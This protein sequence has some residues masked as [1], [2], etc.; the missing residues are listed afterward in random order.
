MK[1]K[2]LGCVLILSAFLAIID[3]YYALKWV[4]RKVDCSKQTK[5][6]YHEKR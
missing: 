1:D 3:G 2:V 6:I 5:E 4:D